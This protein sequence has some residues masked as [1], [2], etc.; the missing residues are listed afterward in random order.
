MRYFILPAVMAGIFFFPRKQPAAAPLPGG[1]D[2]SVHDILKEDLDPTV[3]PSQDFF[4][5]ANG[6]WI[7]RN[8]IPEDQSSWGIG[9]AV[10]EE[11]YK[12]LRTINDQSL[13]AKEGIARKVGDFWYSAMDTVQINQQKLQPIRQELDEI[14]S[15]KNRQDLLNVIADLHVKGIGVVFSSGAEQDA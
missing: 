10:Q 15:I 8:P 14:N 13:S 7:K 12:R 4:L 6:G 2:S 11:L 1:K 9:N 3:D 5:Y